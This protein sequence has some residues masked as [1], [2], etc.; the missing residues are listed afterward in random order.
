MMPK[1]KHTKAMQS[2]FEKGKRK[3]QGGGSGKL[4]KSSALSIKPPSSA[5]Q[6][7]ALIK[8]INT[9]QKNLMNL[10]AFRPPPFKKGMVVNPKGTQRSMTGMNTGNLDPSPSPTMRNPTSLPGGKRVRAAHLNSQV[11]HQHK[12]EFATK[13]I[14]L[15][16]SGTKQVGGK[17]SLQL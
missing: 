17:S 13:K 14:N 11:V 6:M 4:K 12:K 16:K 7:K 3:T 9:G 5:Q 8:T 2:L 1:Q 15:N 10:M